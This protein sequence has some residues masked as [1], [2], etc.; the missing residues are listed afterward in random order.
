MFTESI[1]PCPVYTDPL[2]TVVLE[3]LFPAILAPL[4]ADGMRLIQQCRAE[5]LGSSH[6]TNLKQQ[7]DDVNTIPQDSGC[8]EAPS[9]LHQI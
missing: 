1:V 7:I 3:H 5:R 6:S 8:G 4:Q 2:V 9:F